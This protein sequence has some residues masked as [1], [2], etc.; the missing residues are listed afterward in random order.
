MNCFFRSYLLG[1]LFGR[2][3]PSP[4]HLATKANF[5]FKFFLMLG[6]TL[7]NKAITGGLISIFLSQPLKLALEILG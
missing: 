7:S 2:S 5:D 3:L 4:Q 1:R 6:T